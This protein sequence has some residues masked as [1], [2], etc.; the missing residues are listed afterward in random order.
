MGNV[1]PRNWVVWRR[2]TPI[3]FINL[4][5][6]DLHTI[7]VDGVYYKLSQSFSLSIFLRRLLIRV[8]EVMTHCLRFAAVILGLKMLH[9]LAYMNLV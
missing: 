2:N 7:S 4:V 3:D 6:T 1:K 5:D 8:V 9:V